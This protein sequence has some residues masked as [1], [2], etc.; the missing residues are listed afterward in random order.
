VFS[1]FGKVKL[2]NWKL[3]RKDKKVMK[4]KIYTIQPVVARI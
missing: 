3:K 4:I 2:F 1:K